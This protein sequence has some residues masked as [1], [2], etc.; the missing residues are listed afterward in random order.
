MSSTP[1][2]SIR[3]LSSRGALGRSYSSRVFVRRLHHA[4]PMCR[5]VSIDRA[6]LFWLTFHQVYELVRLVVH[7]TGGFYAGYGGFLRHPL[8]AITYDLSLGLRH[9]EAKRHAHDHD[10]AHHIPGL[11]W[12][13]LGGSGIIIVKHTSQQS[14]EGWLSSGCSPPPS[15]PRSLPEVHPFLELP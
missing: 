4:L 7:L 2:L 10:H 8:R 15:R 12:Q 14:Y 5:S 1:A 3:S 9:G 6:V 13:M 11:L